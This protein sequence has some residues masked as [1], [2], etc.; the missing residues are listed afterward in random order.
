MTEPLIIV[1]P[2]RIT[3]S[4]LE[5]L[6]LN[7]TY[8]NAPE[9]PPSPEFGGIRT[10]PANLLYLHTLFPTAVWHD[11]H[12]R[13]VEAR[14]YRFIARLR[15][16]EPGEYERAFPFKLQ[17]KDYQL[18]LFTHARRMTNIAMAPVALGV[19]KSKMTIDIAA[20]KFLRDEID[21]LIVIA[22]N[23][24]HRQWVESAIPEHMPECVKWVGAVWKPTRKTPKEIM[25]A[26]LGVRR[27]RVLTFNVES[28]SAESGK[29]AKEIR[30]LM[31]TGRA[32]LVMDEAQRIKN[33]RAVRTKTIVKLRALAAV[34]VILTATPVTKGMEDI[35]S[36]YEFLDPAIIGMTNYYAFRNRYCVMMPAYRGAGVGAVKITGYKNQEEL[37]RKIAPMSFMI[38]PD[39]LGLR[40]PRYDRFEVEP[41][42][43]QT[44]IYRMLK[45]MLIEDLRDRKIV[46]PANAAVRILRMQQVLCG[47]YYERVEVE[48]EEEV[49]AQEPRLIPSN[50]PEALLNLLEQH[51]GQ[52]VIWARFRE[53][54]DDIVNA[55]GGVGRVTIYDGRTND[56]ERKQ[57]VE[58]FKRGDIDYFVANPA[59]GGTG[60]DGLQVCQNAFYY[61]NSYNAETRWQSEGR[62]YRLGQQG[63]PLYVDLVVSN[64]VD[65]MI[66]DNLKAKRDLGKAIMDN[67]AMLNGGL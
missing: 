3:V 12:N 34:R 59:A 64:S 9:P 29:A 28:L 16:E 10:S 33:P 36:Q 60:V 25:E 27:I 8:A 63:S 52:A 42:A 67:P 15:Q 31:A 14:A 65:T 26:P 47:R 37:I 35:Y 18:K 49:Y 57:S 46:T 50:R 17:P 6:R 48:G 55:V 1:S 61:S 51:D 66:L 24:V 21:I 54:I 7:D 43:E 5:T 30:K 40:E 56:D 39:V 44:Q 62:T 22:P 38:T 2:A 11:P 23:G 32:M 41:T 53:D 19:G 13:L 58:A 4:R 20:D 45:E